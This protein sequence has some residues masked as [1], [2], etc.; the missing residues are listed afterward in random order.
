M[1]DIIEFDKRLKKDAAQYSK[2]K[3]ERK[4]KQIINYLRSAKF[5]E[6]IIK[7]CI[8]IFRE[9]GSYDKTVETL[10]V[11]EEYEIDEELEKMMELYG[12]DEITEDE[13]PYEWMDE[14][15]R[16]CRIQ[17]KNLCKKLIK[18]VIQDLGL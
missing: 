8:E 6:R 16:I 11:M 5:D 15:H 2:D 10:D 12:N 13:L 14:I 9:N 4:S 7:L 17:N 1:S 18:K 3:L